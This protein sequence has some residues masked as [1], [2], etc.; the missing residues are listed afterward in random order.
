M[1]KSKAKK[2]AQARQRR[3]RK[4]Y[5]EMIR[6]F[7]LQFN[8]LQIGAL[9]GKY[10]P[11]AEDLLK[12][13]GTKSGLKNPTKQTIENLRRLSKRSDILRE[14]LKAV[15]K[16]TG[17]ESP[18]YAILKERFENEWQREK[19]R[20]KRP[21]TKDQKPPV[22]PSDS[23]HDLPDVN[24]DTAAIEVVLQQIQAV[25]DRI[26]TKNFINGADQQVIICGETISE[27]VNYFLGTGTDYQI[28]LLNEGAKKY[29]MTQKQVEYQEL[30][31]NAPVLRPCLF[32]ELDRTLSQGDRRFW[33]QEN[34]QNM[35]FTDFNDYNSTADWYQ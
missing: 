4:Q 23:S 32:D 16:K 18:E 17:K 6:D 5:A 7:K 1:A 25:S 3:R 12:Q 31:E 10:S 34:A 20:R 21:P 14:T 33:E 13:V 11:S 26:H 29:F 19:A 27:K 8:E 15:E 2:N 28:Y 22:P 35:A 24:I 9:A 30:Y